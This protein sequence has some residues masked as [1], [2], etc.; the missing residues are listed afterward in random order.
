MFAIAIKNTI[1]VFLIILIFHFILKN[2]QLSHTHKE[3]FEKPKASADASVEKVLSPTEDQKLDT[4]VDFSNTK[5]DEEELLKYVYSNKET[6]FMKEPCMEIK[7]DIPS[8]ETLTAKSSK[9]VS[10]SQQTLGDAMLIGAYDDESTMNGATIFGGL[11]GFDESSVNYVE[12][13]PFIL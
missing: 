3:T 9:T 12:Y 2:Q 10:D 5:N 4:F 6:D 8:T 7:T 1:L 11:Q 13:K